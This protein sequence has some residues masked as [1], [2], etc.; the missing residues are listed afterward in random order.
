META[1]VSVEMM[2]AVPTAVTAFSGF[3]FFSA[4]AAAMAIPVPAASA[5]AEDAAANLRIP[6]LE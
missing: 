3:S 2:D 6:V 5:V 4:S 1:A